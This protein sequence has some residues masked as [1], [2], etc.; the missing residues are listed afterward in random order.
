MPLHDSDSDLSGYDTYAPTP[1]SREPTPLPDDP[2][3]RL[4][5]DR[6]RFRWDEEQYQFQ[7]I[8]LKEARVDGARRKHEDEEGDRR[9][10]E[11]LEEI[12]KVRY[13]PG[14]LAKSGEYED[15]MRKFNLRAK[16][17]TQEQ[18]DA[19]EKDPMQYE[20]Q[21]RN[22]DLQGKGWTQEQIGAADRADIAFEKWK[23]KTLYQRDPAFSVFTVFH[24][25]KR[26]GT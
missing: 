19:K 14:T 10:E 5:F 17:L 2:W 20:R 11:E 12:R 26:K 3:E 9:R 22:N 4:E 15:R 8:F 7:R 25:P 24:L 13:L 21:E 23:Q 6:R 18:I 1:E 16:G